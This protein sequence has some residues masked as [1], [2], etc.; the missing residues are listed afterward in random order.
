[1]RLEIEEEEKLLEMVKQ[2]SLKDEEER[3]EK[4]KQEEQKMEEIVHKVEEESI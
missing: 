1:M 3:Q 4:V 2:A